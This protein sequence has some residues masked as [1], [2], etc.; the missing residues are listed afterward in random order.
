[1]LNNENKE[2]A[3]KLINFYILKPNNYQKIVNLIKKFELEEYTKL[4]CKRHSISYDKLFLKNLTCSI[5]TIEDV[6][7]N[8]L[9]KKIINS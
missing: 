7:N 5:Q 2:S 6:N 9:Y 8:E 1:M 4:L 3:K